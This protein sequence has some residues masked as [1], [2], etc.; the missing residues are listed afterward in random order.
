MKGLAVKVSG[1]MHSDLPS[2]VAVEGLGH[3]KNSFK[4]QGFTDRSF[5]KW[6]ARKTTDSH[7]RDRTRYRSSRIGK[8][9]S[10]T[11]YGRTLQERPILTGHASAGNKLRNSFTAKKS[12]ERVSFVTYKQYAKRHNEGLNGMPKRKFVGRS[13]ELEKQIEKKIEKQLHIIFNKK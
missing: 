3:I 7:G 2:I 1:F 12:P 4:K 11:R 9:G 13:D 6:K 5:V 8:K 10:L